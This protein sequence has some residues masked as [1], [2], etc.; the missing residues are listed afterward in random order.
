MH[1][2]ITNAGKLLDENGNLCEAGWARSL[3]KEYNRNAIRASGLRIKEWDYYIVNNQNYGV[4]LTVAD[5]AYMGLISV[6]VLDLASSKEH[7]ESVM[8]AFPMG[9]FHMPGSSAAGDVSF[10][11][12]RIQI[13]FEKKGE[14]R[15]LSCHFNKFYEEKPLDV[16][17]E[18]YE[19]AMDTMVIATPFKKQKHFYYNQKINCMP[20]SGTVNYDGNSLVFSPESS[21]ATLDWGRG[22]WTYDNTW[23]WGNANGV[24]DGK[25]LGFNIGY[26]FGDTSAASENLVIYDG[27]AHKLS[28]ISF[29]IPEEGY[30]HPWTFSSDDKRFEMDFSPVL[31]RSSHINALLI[32]SDQ[33]QVFGRF[34][35][36][37]ILD[38]GTVLH[39][40]DFMGF[41][42]KVRNRY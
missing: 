17:L 38:D 19:P 33:H 13:S 4:A 26:G 23:Y 34:T 30:M 3:I 41:A 36:E 12:K 31:D 37:I 21:F 18:L 39:L 35:G 9:K 22:V 32:E 15:I 1:Y 40:K 14:K 29:N 28:E 7:T 10:S 8:T 16:H 2:E 11:N 27:I 5:N 42:E 6:S 24:L 20:A 25:P